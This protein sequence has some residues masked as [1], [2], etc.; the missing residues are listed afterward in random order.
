MT[1]EEQISLSGED[2]P[3]ALGDFEPL[4]LLN[5]SVAVS[6]SERNELVKINFNNNPEQ[7]APCKKK[8]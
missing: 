5:I 1:T 7:K 3:K 4:K 8:K 2:K 6:E